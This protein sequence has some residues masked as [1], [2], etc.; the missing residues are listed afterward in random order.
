MKQENPKNQKT[1]TNYKIS[2]DINEGF[3]TTNNF[4]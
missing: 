1:L 2:V 4:N 3:N